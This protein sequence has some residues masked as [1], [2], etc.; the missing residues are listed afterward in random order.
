[1]FGMTTNADQLTVLHDGVTI[2]VTRGGQGRPLVLCPGLTST[3]ADLQELIGLLRRDHDV[4]TFDLRG[5]GFSS[6]ADRY[7]FGAFLGD[8][9]AVMTEVGCLGLPSMPVLVG[10]SLGADLIVHYAA[11]Y[12]D[13]VAELVLIDGAN[14]LPS[15]FIADADLPELRAL[16]ENSAVSLEAATGTAHQVLLTPQ[17]ILE[18]NLELDVM[19][20]GIL[21]RYRMIA[22]PIRMIVSTAMAGH[23]GQGRVPRHNRLWR[24]GME[25]LAREQ[26]H[27]S[28]SWLD[29][30]HALVQT[31]ARDIARTIT[32]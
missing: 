24:S 32:S 30:T 21:D 3:Q 19:R 25:R 5:H 28:M 22:C 16:W 12:P 23:S 27:V 8:L 18:L 15:P 13:T 1:M 29:A 4:L 10:H 17:E 6:P 20:A 31:H 26:P 11:R 14:P 7:S 2:P 9:V